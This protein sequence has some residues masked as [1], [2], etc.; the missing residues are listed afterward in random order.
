MPET[1]VFPPVHAASQHLPYPPTERAADVEYPRL[2]RAVKRGHTSQP[3]RQA[4]GWTSH[5]R[6]AG[7]QA[8]GPK[9]PP[10]TG[11]TPPRP[12]N[13]VVFARSPT[14]G[15]APGGACVPTPCAADTAAGTH[16]RYTVL[17]PPLSPAA[18]AVRRKQNLTSIHVLYIRLCQRT[19]VT[20][21]GGCVGG[22]RNVQREFIH[23]TRG[24]RA[25]AAIRGTYCLADVPPRPRP[26]NAAR[27]EREPPL[28]APRTAGALHTT[29]TPPQGILPPLECSAARPSLVRETPCAHGATA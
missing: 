5:G 12:D 15:E 20:A 8:V 19:Q 21:S 3:Q 1:Y 10:P 6:C 24:Q 26:R 13:H 2:S 23:G 11:R 17:C 29:P 7:S 22:R 9:K 14:G 18:R 27:E 4:T 16:S 28:M 25:S